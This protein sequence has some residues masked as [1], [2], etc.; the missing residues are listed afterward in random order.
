M[1]D[2]D[3]HESFLQEEFE[4]DLQGDIWG[5]V[6][7]FEGRDYGSE[8]QKDHDRWYR[9]FLINNDPWERTIVV[10]G[11]Q[12]KPGAVAGPLPAFAMFELGGQAA[13]WFGVGG[14]DYDPNTIPLPEK[15]MAENEAPEG[16]NRVKVARMGE[17]GSVG[18]GTG[19]SAT[20]TGTTTL[21]GGEITSPITA[22]TAQFGSLQ[23]GQTQNQPVKQVHFRGDAPEF[24]PGALGGLERLGMRGGAGTEDDLDPA[25]IEENRQRME[26]AMQSTGTSQN[27]STVTPYQISTVTPQDMATVVPL[28]MS[29]ETQPYMSTGAL[30]S[31]LERLGICVDPL[32]DRTKLLNEVLK[33][34]IPHY[35]SAHEI[36]RAN[37][38]TGVAQA[39][40][41]ERGARARTERIIAA[42]SENSELEQRHMCDGLG[43]IISPEWNPAR[44][45]EELARLYET[46]YQEF[47]TNNSAETE[48]EA[49]MG[50][51][52][53]NS[54][55]KEAPD[56]VKILFWLASRCMYR[57]RSEAGLKALCE[58][59]S[60]DVHHT[61]DSERVIMEIMRA[62]ERQRQ[63]GKA[64]AAAHEASIAASIVTIAAMDA[65]TAIIRATM[66]DMA[67]AAKIKTGTTVID[68]TNTSMA[69][70]LTHS[71]TRVDLTN[72]PTPIDLTHSP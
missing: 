65:E 54:E 35:Q 69:I 16:G 52:A 19:G 64:R 49:D 53:N 3:S 39:H 37:T 68:L 4:Y 29:A 58:K 42:V 21:P 50:L 22:A 24:V 23:I 44:I 32:W 31:R 34:K 41:A 12:V 14:R 7:G 38:Q 36:E 55:P 5:A 67:N 1:D 2:G 26:A 15:R 33:V 10:N 51:P 72:G 47:I 11:V 8:R 46:A 48:Y 6:G 20:T 71:P 13:F 62:V 45:R 27:I 30:E 18:Q 56:V 28:Y 63:I 17:A 25:V 57:Q 59:Y 70:D 66:A 40:E 43:I 61:W 60:I 9:Y